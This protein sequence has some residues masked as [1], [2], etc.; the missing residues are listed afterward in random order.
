MLLYEALLREAR[1]G[2]LSPEIACH[3]EDATVVLIDNVSE[4]YWEDSPQEFWDLTVDFPNVAP[5]WPVAFYEHRQPKFMNINGTITDMSE[6]RR[7]GLRFGLLLI[8]HPAERAID[9]SM[10]DQFYAAETMRAMITSSFAQ[11]G[12]HAA[13]VQVAN[14]PAA[15]IFQAVGKDVQERYLQVAKRREA[16]VSD[17]HIRWFCEAFTVV[18]TPGNAPVPLMRYSFPVTET[19]GFIT[20]DGKIAISYGPIEQSA[21]MLDTVMKIGYQYLHVPFL[22]ISLSHCRNV[23]LTTVDPPEKLSR[24]QLK[25]YG[26]PKVRYHVLEISPMRKVLRD[27]GQ[28]QKHGLQK[29]LHICRGHFKDYRERGLFGR[30][31]GIYWWDMHARGSAEAGAV[32]KDYRVSRGT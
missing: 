12:D 5:P 8:A 21:E 7:S 31:K 32:V 4:F 6:V 27:E 19:G 20:H 17:H 13:A 1:R 22:A 29:A 26:V 18:W 15:D 25:R 10:S 28:S 16:Y 24:K 2:D 11:S 30:N 14:M 9:G 23:E 3:I